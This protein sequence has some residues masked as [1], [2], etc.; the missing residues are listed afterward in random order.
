MTFKAIAT[1][2]KTKEILNK[3][4]FSFKKSLGQNFIIDVNIL[5]NIIEAAGV[6]KDTAVIEIGPGI[7][8][9]TEQLARHSKQVI[10]F[11]IDQRLTP[12]LEDTLKDYANLSIV[13]QD[14]LK[15]DVEQIVRTYFS[16][17]HD[18]KVVA[19]LPYYVTTP[20]L[21][22]LLMER[23]PISSIT[24]MIQKEVA[25]RMAAKP[26][27]KSYGSLS[28]AV[29]YFTEATVALYVPKTVFMPQPNVDS[30]VLHLSQRETPLVEVADEAF[31]FD[32]VQAA[33][34]QRRKTLRNN[35][36]R[37]FAENFTKAEIEVRL[38]RAGIDG[39]RRGESLS[40]QEF[41]DLANVF[42]KR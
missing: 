35:L 30:A 40:I 34:A 20:I 7:G 3:Y 37:Y 22:K 21:M 16:N 29:Q 15:A 32:L 33:F 24:V 6:S 23:L 31:F 26:N 5:K 12:I 42:Y 11:E 9:L 28:I 25:D 38:K 36:S 19:N 18:I 41:A 39:T 27:T 10:A 1:P 2:T 14:V 13:Y 4:G 8:A 17:Q